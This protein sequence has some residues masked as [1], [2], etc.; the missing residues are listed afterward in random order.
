M[1]KPIRLLMLSACLGVSAEAASAQQG[2]T[3]AGTPWRLPADTVEMRLEGRG[4]T[5]SRATESQDLAFTRP[6]GAELTVFLQTGRAVG[7][8]LVDPARGAQVEPRFA[9]L[10]DSLETALGVPDTVGDA[11]LRWAAGLTELRLQVTR[12]LN[13]PYV[14]L[15]WRGPGM[16]DEMVRRWG[17]RPLPPLPAGFTGVTGTA[18]SR[19][20]VDTAQLG[21]RPD[22][23]LRAHF[24]IDYAQPVGPEDDSYDSAEYE[25]DIDCA[26][27]RTR[28]FARTLFLA[29]Q[30]RKVERYQRPALETPQ[31]AGHNAR[32]LEAVCRAAQ[33]IRPRALPAPAPRAR[34]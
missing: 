8:L 10:A 21:R 12:R 20:A 29:G 31:P 22:G 28:L 6:D 34:R 24:R 14:T 5:F 17:D 18:V 27:R 33:T 30:S 19:V 9:T 13:V 1:W 16:L 25:M 11:A 2:L 7:F 23:V 4:Y 15:E 3:F 32:G 26:Q